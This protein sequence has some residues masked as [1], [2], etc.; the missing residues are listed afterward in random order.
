MILV[1]LSDTHGKHRHFAIPPGDVLIHAG[2]FMCDHR[3]PHDITSFISWFGK[4]PH[5]H[6]IL[7]AGNH[8]GFVQRHP[9]ESRKLFEQSNTPVHYLENSGVE[10]EGVRFW[11][12]PVQPEFNN[13]FF[14]VPRGPE[15]KKYWDKI[16]QSTDV[17][18][19]H[20]PPAGIRDWVKP[21]QDSLGC[22]D[23]L[24][25]VRR[26]KPKVHVFG[27]IHGGYGEHESLGTRFYNASLLN[28]AYQA[29]NEP[30]V[31]ELDNPAVSHY[32]ILLD[33][34]EKQSG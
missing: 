3:D 8:D 7:V 21:G 6:K 32:G 24:Q 34:S 18:I 27:H 31:V 10:L 15:I 4:Q 12:S 33:Q 11:G 22:W 20:G 30:H 13:W 26:V 25:A 9:E 2:D 16:P 19:T 5:R 23:L 28:E 17:L 29:T 14:N 1:L